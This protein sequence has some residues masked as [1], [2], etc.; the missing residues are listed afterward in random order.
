MPEEVFVRSIYD[1][2]LEWKLEWSDGYAL[3]I[4]GARRVGKSTAVREFARREFRTAM[5][6]DFYSP[7]PG[8]LEVFEMYWNDYGRLFTELQAIYSIDL[9]EGESVVVFDEVQR[10]PRAREMIKGL[11]EDGRYRYIETGSLITLS[12]ASAGIMIPSEEYRV[13]MHPMDFHE[14][15][16]AMGE[17]RKWEL[18]KEGFDR[19]EPVGAVHKEL[20]EI[21]KTYMVVGGMPQAVARF[22]KTRRYS[23]VEKV[24]DG[25]LSLYHEDLAKIPVNGGNAAKRIF[26][27]VPS[28]LSR[29]EKRFRP[30]G[31]KKGSR[32]SDY[33]DSIMWLKDSRICNVCMEIRDLQA[34]L[35]LTADETSLKCYLLD[36]GLLLTQA[37]NER[38]LERDDVRG[39]FVRGRLGMNEGMLFENSVAQ[40]LVSC[41]IDL[42]FSRFYTDDKHVGEVDFVVGG[43][44]PVPIEVKSGNSSRHASLDRFMERNAGRVGKAYVIHAADLRIDG[45][46]TYLPAYMAGML[47]RSLSGDVSVDDATYFSLG[48]R[49]TRFNWLNVCIPGSGN[50]GR[51]VAQMNSNSFAVTISRTVT[52]SVFMAAA[53]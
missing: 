25:I 48:H 18:A 15:C 37:F 26:D 31:V 40:E 4:K 36:T 24:K 3:L 52:R 17:S 19:M 2:M 12:C 20:M 13:D 32:T 44:R 22:K 43:R 16:I 41:G 42:R 28:M 8:T 47:G 29:H 49:M 6:I 50:Q 33:L 27:L 30:G 51:L 38:V 39:A 11:V 7:R 5:V 34:A 9:Y 53:S 14:F 46:L 1:K 10:Y 21:Y 45:P 35:D 23:D